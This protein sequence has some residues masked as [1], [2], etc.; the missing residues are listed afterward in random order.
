MSLIY[1]QSLQ[2][3]TDTRKDT[4]YDKIALCA[5]NKDTTL[6]LVVNIHNLEGPK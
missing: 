6:S 5:Q 3:K 2:L 1:W 4:C